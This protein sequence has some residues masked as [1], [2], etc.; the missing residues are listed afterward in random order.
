MKK[1]YIFIF[2]IVSSFFNFIYAANTDIRLNSLGFLPTND[3][4]AT[5]HWTSAP[6]NW[7][8]L[9]SPGNVT[10]TSGTFSAPMSDAQTGETNNLYLAIFSSYTTE[11]TYYLNVPTVG[12]SS[13]FDIRADV[14]NDPFVPVFKAMYEWRCGTAV[15]VTYGGNTFSHA[16]CHMN[17]AYDDNVGGTGTKKASLKGWHDAGDYGKYI[18]NAGITMGCLFD[19]WDMFGTQINSLSYGL[20]STAPGYPEFLEELK[21][22]TDWMLTMQAANGSVY[23]KVSTVDFDP[24]E[25]PELDTATRYFWGW[26]NVGTAETGQF[27]AVMAMAARYFQPYDAAYATTC[28]NAATSAYNFLT[29]HLTNT[30]ANVTGCNTG[31]YTGSDP[32]AARLWAAVEM[33]ETIGTGAYLTDAETRINGMNPKIDTDWDWNGQKNLGMF[34]Y[35]LSTRTGKNATTYNAVYNALITSANTIVSTRN[36]HAYGRSLGTNYYWGCNGSEARAAMILQIANQ[37]SPNASYINTALDAIGY[38]F[39]RNMHDR[40]YVTGVGINPAMN[41]HHRPSG[42]D[43]I[44]NPWP[45]YLVGGSS[46]GR[47]DPWQTANLAN[48]LPA[49]QYWSDVEDSYSSNEVAI[50]WQGAL[51]Y[52]MAGF[53]KNPASPTATP[54]STAT[55]TN[56]PYAGTPTSTFTI[57]PLPTLGVVAPECVQ[58]STFIIDGNLNEPEWST[59][60][61]RHQR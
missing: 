45:G 52:A 11:G 39:G 5:I 13:I 44:T 34:T 28:L 60:T 35:L 50:N 10:V 4:I 26:N 20:P 25:L 9:T 54:T 48:G 53:V 40:S 41:P 14:Y 42:G 23:E 33:W 37:L 18:V 59:G 51:I 7:Y 58:G 29:G 46:G 30:T 6:T 38:L 22:E 21:W 57:T 12:K 19:A 15:T 8:L 3:K 49:A 55:P 47:G 56:T 24:F 27:C 32:N 16:A 17:D 36:S 1:G 31:I 61:W 2:L 43:T